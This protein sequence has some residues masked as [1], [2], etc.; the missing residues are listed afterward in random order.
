MTSHQ[1]SSI[2]VASMSELLPLFAN[3]FPDKVPYWEIE[4]S[5]TLI[6]NL[7]I[8]GSLD[9][10]ESWPSGVLLHS[11]YFMFQVNL[12]AAS[13]KLIWAPGNK[14]RISAK[15]RDSVLGIAQFPEFTGTPEQCAE[16]MKKWLQSVTAYLAE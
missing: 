11:M 13:K 7:F 15:T 9:P 10:E 4:A 8:A 16:K 5:D 14:V 12:T 2:K 1:S 3:P 6:A